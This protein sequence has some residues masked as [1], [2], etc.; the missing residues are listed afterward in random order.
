MTE[1]HLTVRYKKT[2]G[3]RRASLSAAAESLSAVALAGVLAWAVVRP[4]G[5]AEAVAAVP[6]AGLVIAVGA[7]PARAA[8]SEAEQPQ[9]RAVRGLGLLGRGYGG[10]D[11]GPRLAEFAAV[12]A[13]ELLDAAA[14]RLGRPCGQVRRQGRVEREVV[15]A[16][17]DADLLVVARDGDRSRL[18]PKSL[19]KA[20][21]F[22]VDHAPCPVLLVWPETAPGIDSIPPPKRK[23][24]GPPP[25]GPP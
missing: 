9:V 8:V 11:P 24:P 2:H 16:A 4:R 18:G 20:T 6:A 22:I 7:L 3:S 23:P 19:G 17:A 12:S 15:T 14:R 25:V 13:G 1:A 5:W 10:R 21:R